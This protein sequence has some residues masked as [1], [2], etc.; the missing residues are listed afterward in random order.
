M[1]MQKVFLSVVLFLSFALYPL[2]SASEGKDKLGLQHINY[3]AT[4]LG[5]EIAIPAQTVL[6]VS[7]SQTISTKKSKLGETINATVN[8][9]VYIGPHLVVPEGSTITGKISDINREAVKKGPNPYIVMDFTHL[10]RPGESSSLPFSATLIAYK[11]GLRKGDYVWRLPHQQDRWKARLSDTLGGAVTGFFINPL[12]G[13]LIGGGAGALKAVA[14]DKVA[15]KGS[16]KV[17]AGEVIPI[18]VQQAFHLPVAT[19][20]QI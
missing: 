7:L 15:E 10:K 12:F 16:I 11:T 3:Q 18:A 1:R 14:I 5:K 8:D 9:P 19:A 20:N 2:A 4:T 13:P 6:N 17:K